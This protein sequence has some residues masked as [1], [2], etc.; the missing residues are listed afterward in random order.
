MISGLHSPIGIAI[1]Y[2]T[3]RLY[4]TDHG[5]QKIQSSGLDGHDVVTVAVVASK[6]FGITVDE[7]Q[8]YWSLPLADLARVESMA[9][10]GESVSIAYNGTAV[11]HLTST[12]WIVAKNRTN[13]CD[14]Q[15]CSGLCVLTPLASR[16]L[17]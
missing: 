3:S 14:G 11:G 9:V 10:A 15:T 7:K 4:C 1:D 17:Q 8:L 13:P 2:S 12:D 5:A 6:P 16:C